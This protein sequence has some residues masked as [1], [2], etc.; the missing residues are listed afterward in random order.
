MRQEAGRLVF[1]VVQLG[2][3]VGDFAAHHEQ[4]K[5]LGD[6]GHRVGSARQWRH[7]DRVVDD[8]GRFPQL[9]FSRL[10][11]QRQLQRAQAGRGERLDAEFLQFFLDEFRIVQLLGSV[12]RSVLVDRFD[13]GQAVERLGQVQLAAAV[14]QGG[15]AVRIDGGL[16]DD[17]FRE[18]HQPFVVGVGRVEF[19][20]R[21]FRVVTDRHAFIAEVAVDFEHAVEAAHDQALQVQLG[22]DTQEHLHVQRIVVRDEWFGRGAARDRVQ[23]RRFHFHELVLFHE[24]ADRRDGGGTRLEGAARLFVHD[25]VDVALAVLR[26]LVGQAVEFVR[27]RAQ[28]LGDQTQL[29]D[30]DGQFV[31][32]GLEQRARHAQDIAQVIVVQGGHGRFAREVERGVD[33]DAAVGFRAGSVLQGGEGGFLAR[34][35]L[36]HHAAGQHH[37]DRFGF[38]LF[39]RLAA[40]LRVQIGRL[41]LGAEIVREGDALFAQCGQLDAALGDDLVFIGGG[42]LFLD[43][44]SHGV[45]RW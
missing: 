3:A 33:L 13:D 2:E 16:A 26:F 4:F 37:G 19:H 17:G 38:Q 27:Q 28:R 10:F 9:S 43:I 7:F 5:T 11:E 8:I 36:E 35:A 18:V 15:G 14:G 39:A 21:E 22:R 23:H 1:R 42:G 41:V 25:Q 30:L 24:A 44:R 6:A 32:L 20:H 12:A 34:F 45:L 29:G 40:V 31:R